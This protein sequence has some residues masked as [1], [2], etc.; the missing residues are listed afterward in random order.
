MLVG[1]L[2][3]EY[4]TGRAGDKCVAADLSSLLGVLVGRRNADYAASEKSIDVESPS[5]V[6]PIHRRPGDGVRSDSSK[7]PEMRLVIA[8]IGIL[9]CIVGCL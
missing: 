8:L 9:I 4:S 2:L 7:V 3:A 1:S 6:S 5:P